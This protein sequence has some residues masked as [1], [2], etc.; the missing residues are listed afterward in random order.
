V[1]LVVEPVPVVPVA[2]C[3]D[4]QSV[5][6]SLILLPLA[7]VVVAV[8]EKQLTVPVFHSLLPVTNILVA[9]HVREGSLAVRLVVLERDRDRSDAR[10]GR[11]NLYKR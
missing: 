10:E 8:V 5:P 11:Y 4:E 3:V 6:A 2:V 1:P 7:V 9:M